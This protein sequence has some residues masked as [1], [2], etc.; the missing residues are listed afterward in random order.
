MSDEKNDQNSDV[1]PE[2]V[3]KLQEIKDRCM[4]PAQISY[5]VFYI[6]LLAGSFWLYLV[7]Q[8]VS[9]SADWDSMRYAHGLLPLDVLMMRNAMV[10]WLLPISVLFFFRDVLQI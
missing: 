9:D 4:P 1:T 5:R 2:L 7:H 3:Q 10:P 6:F 8:M